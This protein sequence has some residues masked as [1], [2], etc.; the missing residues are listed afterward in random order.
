MNIIINENQRGFLYKNGVFKRLLTPGKHY[1]SKLRGYSILTNQVEG[2]VSNNL[3]PLDVLMED[4]HFADNTIHI[5]VKENTIALHFI[6]ERIV[7]TLIPGQYTYWNI[8][9]KHTFKAIDISKPEVCYEDISFSTFD[10]IPIKLYKKLE[11]PEGQIALLYFNGKLE[12]ELSS[13]IYFFWNNSIKVTHQLVDLRI[14][15]LDI[16]GQEILT[17]DKVSLRINFVCSYKIIDPIKL[18][19]TLSNFELQ[20]YILT[21]LALREYI[22]KFRFDEFLEQK[23]GIA[24]FV[25]QKLQEKQ[26]EYY[27]EFIS[28]GIKDIVLPGEIRD[29]MNTVLVA[30]KTAQ[31]NVI[32]RREEV[33]ST[34]SLLNTAKLMDENQTLFKLKE[35]EY[36][37][38]ICDKIG[39]ISLSGG[40]NVLT[41]LHEL[42][43]SK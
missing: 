43:V 27:I 33:A 7:E 2:M 10:Y 3:T 39:H 15:Q 23:N 16:G 40:N 29:I 6:D 28:A 4:K 31:A 34:R 35:L 25:L 37:E 1:Y 8:F 20:I 21:Q 19:T 12:R 24:D 41:Q 17:A 26:S 22:G 42:L 38:R 13:G 32:S 36:L 30:E 5:S 14:Q 9:K 11:V 18:V